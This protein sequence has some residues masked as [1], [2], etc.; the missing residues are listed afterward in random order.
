[1]R[2]LCKLYLWNQNIEEN[3]IKN[4]K[5]N[6]HILTFSILLDILLNVSVSMTVIVP[7]KLLFFLFDFN[8]WGKSPLIISNVFYIQEN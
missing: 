1:M 4:I 3:K 5:R 6:L 7:N 8:F 2:I